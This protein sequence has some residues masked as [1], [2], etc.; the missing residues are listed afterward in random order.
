LAKSIKYER[1]NLTN[2]EKLQEITVRRNRIEKGLR[3]LVKNS[4]RLAYGKKAGEKI[5]ASIEE[6]RRNKIGTNNI[7]VLLDRDK[8]PLYFLDLINTIN[9]EWPLFQNVFEMEKEKLLMVLNDIN[10]KWQ[11]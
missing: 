2:D 6:T 5:L 4:L 3:G 9:R 1:I 10:S 11:T 8:S 7:E